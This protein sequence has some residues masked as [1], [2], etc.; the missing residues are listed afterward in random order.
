MKD[1][2]IEEFYEN[3]QLKSKGNYKNGKPD[4]IQESYHVNGQLEYKCM[5]IEGEP[6]GVCEIFDEKGKVVEVLK[7]G[8]PQE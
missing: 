5:N 7:D 8:V 2:L 4:G 6:S 1:G 3:G